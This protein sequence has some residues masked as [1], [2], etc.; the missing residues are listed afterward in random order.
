MPT[1]TVDITNEEEFRA[2]MENCDDETPNTEPIKAK[3][4]LGIE[5]LPPIEELTITVPES[6]C[7]QLGTISGIVDTMGNTLFLVF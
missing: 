7:K 1:P 4:E 3:G 2:F 6:E 5:D